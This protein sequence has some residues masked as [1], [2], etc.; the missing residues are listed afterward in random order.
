MARH[1]GQADPGV[2]GPLAVMRL[3][4]IHTEARQLLESLWPQPEIAAHTHAL[5]AVEA[6]QIAAELAL[7]HAS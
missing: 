6:A 7:P 3:H 5:D 4:R 2:L 1:R